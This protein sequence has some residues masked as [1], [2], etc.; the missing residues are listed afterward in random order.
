[1]LPSG[2]TNDPL[3]T[4][5]PYRLLREVADGQ[6]VDEGVRCFRREVHV[7]VVDHLVDG[8][9]EAEEFLS[10][11]L[12]VRQDKRGSPYYGSHKSGNLGD[13]PFPSCTTRFRPF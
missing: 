11:G 2:G 13:I 3:A 10:G 6:E 4:Q 5:E 12:H 9:P 7:S 1:M 8:D